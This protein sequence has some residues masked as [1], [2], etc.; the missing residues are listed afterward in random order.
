M[1]KDYAGAAVLVAAAVRAA[2][3]AP[4]GLGLPG[5][6]DPVAAAEALARAIPPSLALEALAFAL[7]AAVLPPAL[8]RGR[9][10]LAGWG[11]ALLLAVLLPLNPLALVACVW[12]TVGLLTPRT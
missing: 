9:W 6:R 3:D 12:L 7:A 10:G 2:R 8:A 4:I 1:A 11:A 5:S